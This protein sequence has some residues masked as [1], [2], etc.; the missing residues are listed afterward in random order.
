MHVHSAAT[1]GLHMVTRLGLTDL[2]CEARHPVRR[3]RRQAPPEADPPTHPGRLHHRQTD[4]SA[5]HTGELT[6]PAR[7]GTMP[8]L[9]AP[10]TIGSTADFLRCESGM[11]VLSAS[12][13]PI[14]S[15][16]STWKCNDTRVV[17]TNVVAQVCAVRSESGTSTQAA[18]IVR[19]NRSSTYSLSASTSLYVAG[20]GLLATWDCPR[21]GVAK[22]S[23][24]VC[25]GRTI[26][27][28]YLLV[29]AKGYAGGAE[30]GL[31]PRV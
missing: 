18:V 31:S 13:N 9:R 25:F 28:S 26:G 4:R 16:P 17:D 11:K 10:E 2:L 24:S 12:L 30:L 3:T 15:S 7:S 21:S 1:H 22:N 19:N 20:E 27:E 5:H 29:Y 14:T 6:T 8:I 23:W